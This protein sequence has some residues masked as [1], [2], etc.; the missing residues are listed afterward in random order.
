MSR[1][2]PAFGI[3]GVEMMRVLF[4]ILATI[5]VILLA[6]GSSAGLVGRSDDL[7]WDVRMASMALA[8]AIHAWAFAY[9]WRIARRVEAVVAREGLPDWV[10]AQAEKHRRTALRFQFWGSLAAILGIGLL[11]LEDRNPVVLGASVSFQVG[12]FLNEWMMIENESRLM[13]SLDTRQQ[14]VEPAVKP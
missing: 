13:A 3:A 12:A 14:S 11:L 4:P 1:V 10:A 6:G 7:G 2:R 5:V 9:F 8:L